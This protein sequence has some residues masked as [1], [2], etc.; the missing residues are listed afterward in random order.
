[1]FT[2]V[3]SL[4]PARY[5]ERSSRSE[6]RLLHTADISVFPADMASPSSTIILIISLVALGTSQF[7]G[8]GVAKLLR[9]VV[10]L[11]WKMMWKN[12]PLMDLRKLP[13]LEDRSD[14]LGVSWQGKRC[15]LL[16]SGYHWRHTH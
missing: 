12:S 6:S 15:L 3:Y 14:V 8:L 11:W 2:V 1:M 7:T 9:L 16:H 13:R 10:L 5:N 4:Y